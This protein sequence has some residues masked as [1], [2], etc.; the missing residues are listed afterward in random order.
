MRK[1]EV[2][3]PGSGSDPDFWALGEGPRTIGISSLSFFFSLYI[4]PEGRGGHRGGTGCVEPGLQV[5]SSDAGWICEPEKTTT[6]WARGWRMAGRPASSV[7]LE[8]KGGWKSWNSPRT[9]EGPAALASTEEYS[10]LAKC[11]SGDAL[12]GSHNKPGA[13]L[14]RM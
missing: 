2:G 10:G 9:T 8:A 7:G 11:E 4:C 13:R 1:G 3:P 12:R 6:N 14:G 5:I